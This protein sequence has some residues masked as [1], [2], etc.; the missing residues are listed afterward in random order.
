[1]LRRKLSDPYFPRYVEY[2]VLGGVGGNFLSSQSN[3]INTSMNTEKKSKPKRWI[4]ELS[5]YQGEKT[6]TVNC[7][8]LGDGY[9]VKDKKRILNEWCDFLRSEPTSFRELTFGTRMPQQLFDA[10]SNQQDLVRLNIKWGAYKD[11]SSIEHL[12]N[13]ESLHIGSGAGVQRIEPLTRLGKLRELG[14][15]NFQK[16]TDYSPLSSLASLRALSIEGDG[17]GPRYIKVES[18]DFLMDLP[19]LT[20]FTFLTARLKSKDYRPVLALKGLTHLTLPSH[21]D[22]R[23]IYDELIELPKLSTGL[24]V[25]KPDLYGR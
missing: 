5:E 1:M 2:G 13:M 25:E 15:E 9:S 24:L 14:V 21:R 19:T 22:V 6:I 20:S 12:Q 3:G 23:T 16:I 17:L 18:L 11:I 10:V 8:Q 7:T 4:V